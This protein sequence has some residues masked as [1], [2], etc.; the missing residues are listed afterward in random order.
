MMGQ[1]GLEAV[2][3]FYLLDFEHVFI[4]INLFS[5]NIDLFFDHLELELSL[6]RQMIFENLFCARS[7]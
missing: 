4:F 6:R 2:F 3:P 7:F 1:I 5:K